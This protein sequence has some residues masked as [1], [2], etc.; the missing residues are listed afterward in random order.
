MFCQVQRAQLYYAHIV[1]NIQDDYHARESKYWIGNM[2]GRINGWCYR[3]HIY[4]ILVD[5]STEY[6]GQYYSRPLP[7]TVYL[8]VL[9][10]LKS[11][12]DRWA[13]SLCEPK[14]E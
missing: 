9:D 11:G 13:Q 1:L 6:R 10:L 12:C 8:Q 5:V 2:S 7:R 3:E 4:G 14:W